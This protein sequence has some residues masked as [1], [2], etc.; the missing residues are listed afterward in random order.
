M[1]TKSVG[2]AWRSFAYLIGHEQLIGFAPLA[3]VLRH[4]DDRAIGVAGRHYPPDW[5]EPELGW[6][7]WDASFEGKGNASEAVLA[8]RHSFTEGRVRSPDVACS[9]QRLLSGSWREF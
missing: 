2:D 4:S 1:G 5:P 6:Q 7:I 9:F 3:I 8:A